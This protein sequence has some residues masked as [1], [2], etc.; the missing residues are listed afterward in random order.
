MLGKLL[1]YEL[2]ST[3]RLMLPLYPAVILFAIIN[4]ITIF[5]LADL[6]ILALP[7]A[8]L[9]TMYVFLVIAVFVMTIVLTL[10]RFYK[11]LL[12]EEGYLMFT[13]PV[14]AHNHILS[15]LITAVIWFVCSVIVSLG[16]V[17]ILIPDYDWIKHIP[18]FYNEISEYL[19]ATANINLTGLIL[20][21]LAIGFVSVVHFILTVYTA[22]SI[23]HLANKNRIFA[24][25]GAYIGI[26]M[27]IQALNTVTMTVLFKDSMFE[28]ELLENEAAAVSAVAN[29][30]IQVLVYTLIT[31][32]VMSVI[33]F[34]V[35]R[36]ILNKKL[37]LE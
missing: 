25:F 26:Y 24:S 37:N 32:I 36:L 14:K 17:L 12:G 30:P 22:I 33:Y 10:Q 34:F 6:E 23:G 35:T 8:L 1:K 28:F 20:L 16:S 5:V 9:M 21:V 19:M 18:A 15:K 2:R 27:V 7:K 3:A 11:N 31:S 4:K 13:L 29:L